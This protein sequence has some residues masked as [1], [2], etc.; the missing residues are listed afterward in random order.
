MSKKKKFT[1]EQQ[2]KALNRAVKILN[3]YD[4]SVTV[5]HQIKIVPLTNREAKDG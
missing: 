1:K 5:E 2:Q 3:D 4:L